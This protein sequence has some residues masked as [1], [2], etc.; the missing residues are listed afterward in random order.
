MSSNLRTGSVATLGGGF[1]IRSSG[2]CSLIGGGG[3]VI[4]RASDGGA[5]AGKRRRPRAP[6]AMAHPR[7]ASKRRHGRREVRIATIARDILR[8][9]T[10]RAAVLISSS[11]SSGDYHLRFVLSFDYCVLYLSHALFT[12]KNVRFYA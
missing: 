6:E 5:C 9:S 12:L 8:S 10:V 11:T 4:Q 2:G 7:W 1:S 3:S